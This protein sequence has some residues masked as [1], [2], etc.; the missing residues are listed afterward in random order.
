MYCIKCGKKNEDEAIFCR[1][2][3]NQLQNKGSK[4]DVNNDNKLDVKDYYEIEKNIVPDNIEADEGEV[5]IK[6]YNVVTFRSKTAKAEGRLQLTNKRVLFRASGLSLKKQITVQDEFAIDE[7]EEIQTDN[8]LTKKI[9][10]I[11]CIG[12]FIM[13]IIYAICYL[14]I[15]ITLFKSLII[16]TIGLIV[17]LIFV[18]LIFNE[19]DLIINIK[20]KNIEKPIPLFKNKWKIIKDREIK[21]KRLIFGRT[22]PTKDTEKAIRE[23]NN[24]I[25]D[26]KRLN[27]LDKSLKLRE[28]FKI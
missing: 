3:G 12:L 25:K 20:I 1:H 21:E 5:P 26:I 28:E 16:Y 10:L 27:N 13:F 8:K 22:I 11:D 4:I 17:Y 6:Q 7:I 9:K 18:N 2:C 14:V 24:I 19:T 15:G 23:I